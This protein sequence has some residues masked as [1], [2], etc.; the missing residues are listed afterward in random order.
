[1]LRPCNLTFTQVGGLGKDKLSG[2]AF[3][4]AQWQSK[5][6]STPRGDMVLLK[7]LISENLKLESSK[8]CSTQ[9]R[10]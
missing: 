1:M 6:F 10:S 5:I 4:G 3:G 2:V 7:N 8:V 9:Q